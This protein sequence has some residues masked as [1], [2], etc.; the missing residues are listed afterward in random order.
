VD[1]SRL[2]L[3]RHGAGEPVVLLHGIGGELGI[4]EPTIE[5]LSRV[6]ET[7]TVDLPG[8][9]RS[10]ALT[11]VAPTPVALAAAVG[12]LLTQL[13]IDSA[14]IVGNSLGAWVALEL[15]R[16]GRARSVLGLCPA[17]LWA[18]PVL[19][20]GAASRATAHR[21][22]RRL[23]PLP[24]VP[25]VNPRTQRIALGAFA[26]HPDR[27][28]ADAAWRMIDSH[29]RTTACD[30]T[31]AAVRERYFEHVDDVNVPVLLA[32]GERDRLV[33]PVRLSAC[34]WKSIM[35]PDCGHIPTWDNPQ[36][37]TKLILQHSRVRMPALAIAV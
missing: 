8:F 15:A 20:P 11:D 35:L 23:G 7:I 36:L 24:R 18:A 27:V 6:R 25:L 1:R 3:E 13:R 21:V 17:G 33:R 14:H 5:P 37:I 26:A 10:P 31:R 22:V 34:H 19:D 4:W 9:G 30:A 28:P 2:N 16:A 12:E 29:A 32:F